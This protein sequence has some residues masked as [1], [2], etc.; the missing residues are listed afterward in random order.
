MIQPLSDLRVSTPRVCCASEAST[1]SE[2]VPTVWMLTLRPAAS[3][4]LE[5]GSKS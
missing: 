1:P 5:L 2:A 4:L 3:C